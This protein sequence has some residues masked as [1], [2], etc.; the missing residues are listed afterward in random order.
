VAQAFK[1]F[2]LTEAEQL[3]TPSASLKTR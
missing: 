3:A 1:M 2:L